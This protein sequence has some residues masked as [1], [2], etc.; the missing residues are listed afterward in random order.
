MLGV[1]IDINF[2]VLPSCEAEARSPRSKLPINLLLI[3]SECK[4]YQ[5]LNE[6][7]KA[8]GPCNISIPHV[9][10]KAEEHQQSA[11]HLN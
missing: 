11:H 3:A 4:T 9:Y 8:K 5:I 6:A 7:T 2:E 10:M 1:G